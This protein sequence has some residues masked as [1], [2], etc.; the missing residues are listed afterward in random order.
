MTLFRLTF[1]GK[2]L[3]RNCTHHEGCFEMIGER[4]SKQS[5]GSLLELPKKVDKHHFYRENMNLTLLPH[6]KNVINELMEQSIIAG[7]TSREC[8]MN[9]MKKLHRKDEKSLYYNVI[10]TQGNF[11]NSIHQD[12]KSVFSETYKK[13]IMDNIVY[14]HSKNKN[15][16]V[17]KLPPQNSNPCTN[18]PTHDIT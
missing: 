13:E 2:G 1:P 14:D 10:I 7:Y 8:I 11:H 4:N 5:T 3:K 18:L 16:Q 12:K 9:Y 15:I 17:S 6:A